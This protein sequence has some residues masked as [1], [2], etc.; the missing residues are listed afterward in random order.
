[1]AIM[2]KNFIKTSIT[3]LREAHLDGKICL[4]CES[5]GL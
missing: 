1:M 3:F 2:L 5:L 4:E